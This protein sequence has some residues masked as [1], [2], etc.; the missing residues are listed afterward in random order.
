MQ[1]RHSPIVWLSQSS[2]SQAYSVFQ[3]HHPRPQR[4]FPEATCPEALARLVPLSSPRHADPKP[5]C[6]TDKGGWCTW[7]SGLHGGG[8]AIQGLRSPAA[9]ACRPRLGT[10]ARRWLEQA[11]AAPGKAWRAILDALGVCMHAQS[12]GA[13][14]AR[15][16]VKT[17]SM[18][19]HRPRLAAAQAALSR[20][21]G[22][23][24]AFSRFSCKVLTKECGVLIGRFGK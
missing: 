9:A 3:A 15:A 4:A 17:A 1:L 12:G 19:H 22:I 13:V 7:T 23:C 24:I 20:P 18:A 10:P 14:T 16:R 11:H 21:C 2:S 8:A 6:S 5:R